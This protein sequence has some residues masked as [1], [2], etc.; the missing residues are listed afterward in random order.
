[1]DI[2]ME[3]EAE[4]AKA[5]KGDLEA[6]IQ[7]FAE[8]GTVLGEDLLGEDL[9]DLCPENLGDADM[10]LMSEAEA[11]ED[12]ELAGMEEESLWMQELEDACLEGGEGSGLDALLDLARSHPGLKITLSF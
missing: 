11:E 5:G 6:D 9:Q 7:A 10:E 1:M 4:L 12:L 3:F 8:S 2:L